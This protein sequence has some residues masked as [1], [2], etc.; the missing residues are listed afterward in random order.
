MLISEQKPF[1]EILGYLDG[2]KNIFLIG[3]KGCAEGWGSGGEKQVAEMRKRLREQGKTIAG[4][5]L[6]DMLCDSALTRLKLRTYKGEIAAADSILV[7]TD[8]AGVQTVAELVNKVVHPGC[9]TL[10][11]GG[12]HAEW[13]EAERCL[14]CGDC[15]LDFT[16][17]ICPIARCSKHLL[18]GPCGGS[19]GGKCE[20]DPEITC[21]WQEIVDQLTRLG[22]L[23]KLEGLVTPKNWSV[24]L[25]SG[26]PVK[27]FS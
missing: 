4:S 5:A 12:A 22:Q 18:N 25:I 14:E 15:M 16:G 1:E 8:G 9:N 11:S 19:Q 26:P 27:R 17:G 6:V 2:D 13:K 21:V 23:N 20:V 7:L 10:S 24:S 3:C